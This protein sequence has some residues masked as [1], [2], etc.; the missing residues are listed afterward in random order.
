MASKTT[1]LNRFLAVLFALALTVGL[2]PALPPSTASAA[3]SSENSALSSCS[4]A[5]IDPDEVDG[6]FIVYEEE[7]AEEIAS[8]PTP[9]S[10]DDDED[11]DDASELIKQAVEDDLEEIGLEPESGVLAHDGTVNVVAQPTEGQTIE[12]AV[13]SAEALPNVK[14]A[15]PNFLIE[16]IE[17]VETSKGDTSSTATTTSS[18]AIDDPY[19]TSDL[20]QRP[21]TYWLYQSGLA[22][23][24]DT[25]KAEGKLTVAYFD[26]GVNLTHE[27]LQD[28]ILT[29]LA[30]DSYHNA[31]LAHEVEQGVVGNGGDSAEH[32]THVA[33]ILSAV[34]NNGIGIAGG[35]YNAKILPIKV[36]ADEK[37]L[38]DGV[39]QNPGANFSSLINAYNYVFS[40]IDN[41][42]LNDL[43]VINISMRYEED[44]AKKYVKLHNLLHET[45]KTARNKY[46]ILTVCGAGNDSSSA[47]CYPS[48]FPECV[49]VESIDADGTDSYYSNYN[50]EK[51]ISAPGSNV[52]ST[53][54]IR[55]V[56]DDTKVDY[57]YYKNISGTSMASPVVAAGFALI[58]AAHPEA[59]IEQ[60]CAAVY[61]TADPIEYDN[62]DR[63][64]KTGSHGAI[65]VDRAI[66][67]DKYTFD[68]VDSTR[69]YFLPIFDAAAKNLI[70]GY[71][72]TDYTTFGPDDL[73]SR[74]QASLM[75]ARM[76]DPSKSFESAPYT[77]M[78]IF[79]DVG[80][81]TH[82]YTGS[83]N[84][85]YEHGIINGY[86][87]LYTTFGSSD[88]ISREQ[89]CIVLY[90]YAKNYLNID[91][92]VS[93][94][95]RDKIIKEY[96]D[97]N[98]TDTWAQEELF[99]AISRGIVGQTRDKTIM[100]TDSMTR[101]YAATILV[102][103]VDNIVSQDS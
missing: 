78:T 38:V 85:N 26:T 99:W 25:A 79:E 100:P 45:I 49:S 88:P 98:E 24:W 13:E 89:F 66:N 34:A 46:N 9:I 80:P 47:A 15:E 36:T 50:S 82:D 101:A 39:W 59:T 11:D 48:D 43:R 95:E 96:N 31:S 75:I 93:S 21:N 84:W 63:A 23:A 91:M 77:E 2:M 103:F 1:P 52:W 6:I 28:N 22:S 29:D 54:P 8:M 69:W 57:G 32:G 20:S 35:T 5:P 67:Y 81:T 56:D 76:A 37:S 12:E 61:N 18:P 58:F 41:G 53:Y 14:F 64:T 97:W 44:Y 62:P 87:P 86:G 42:V 7:V 17:P 68:D 3:V 65:R 94:D 30:W 55:N 51:D 60:A 73:L 71:G 16:L 83:I 10:L 33:G 40:L 74:G 72:S 102:R 27:D 4:S 70:T 19:V 92:D 90:N